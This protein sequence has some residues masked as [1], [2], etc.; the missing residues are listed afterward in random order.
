MAGIS[1]SISLPPSY[2]CISVLCTTRQLHLQV[3]HTNPA[4][5]PLNP[6]CEYRFSSSKLPSSLSREARGKQ[7]SR[8]R[9]AEQKKAQFWVYILPQRHAKFT[10]PWSVSVVPAT[11]CQISDYPAARICRSCNR[12]HISNYHSKTSTSPLHI[13]P[14]SDPPPLGDHSPEVSEVVH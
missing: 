14:V 2:V 13:I 12:I 6:S 8:S 4:R 7:N 9:N 5:N 3:I 10:L 11:L 1:T